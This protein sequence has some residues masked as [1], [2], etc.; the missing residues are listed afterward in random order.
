MTGVAILCLSLTGQHENPA[1]TNAGDWLLTK[2][3]N[4]NWGGGHFFY[5]NYYCT[6]A[7]FQLRGDYWD[8]WAA[9]FYDNALSHQQE[10]GSWETPTKPR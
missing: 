4:S 5:C 7:M 8:Q 1:L 10:D 2:N 6:Q 9:Q 3:V